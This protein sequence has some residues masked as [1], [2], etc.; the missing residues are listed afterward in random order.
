MPKSNYNCAD[1]EENSS[2]RKHNFPEDIVR[3]FLQP[4]D[5]KGNTNKDSD[6]NSIVL[7]IVIAAVVA[8]A[9]IGGVVFVI[10]KKK[11]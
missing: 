11:K 1:E 8:I 4:G 10:I 3:P 2:T 9:I 7:I 5:A 6:D